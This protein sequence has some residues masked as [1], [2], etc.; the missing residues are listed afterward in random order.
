[1]LGF[2]FCCAETRVVIAIANAIINKWNAWLLFFI[3]L[4]VYFENF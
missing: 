2:D 3:C 4:V 1:M